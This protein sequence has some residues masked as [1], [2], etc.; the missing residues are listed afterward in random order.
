MLSLSIIFLKKH[1]IFSFYTLFRSANSRGADTLCAEQTGRTRL[2]RENNKLPCMVTR[3]N[4]WML[5]GV[6]LIKC[7]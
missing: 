6:V 2:V 7:Y 5:E 1:F 3:V 4:R